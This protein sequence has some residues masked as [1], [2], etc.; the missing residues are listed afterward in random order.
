MKATYERV[1]LL[2][3]PDQKKEIARRARVSKASMAEVAR[4]MLDKGIQITREDE[5]TDKTRAFLKKAAEHRKTMPVVNI[6]MADFINQMRE[7][8]HE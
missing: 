4:R 3:R 7:E 5:E 2:I 6:D 1:Q 8:E